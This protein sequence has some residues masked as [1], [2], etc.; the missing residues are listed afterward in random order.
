MKS[1]STIKIGDCDITKQ[2]FIDVN[3]EIAKTRIFIDDN[4][5]KKIEDYRIRLEKEFKKFL[6][7]HRD[8]KCDPDHKKGNLSKIHSLK[9]LDD[10]NKLKTQMSTWGTGSSKV[11]VFG[12]DF[13]DDKIAKKA[14]ELADKCL[15][16]R[17]KS[18]IIGVEKEKA[19]AL[20]AVAGVAGAPATAKE[21]E[22]DAFGFIKIVRSK[23]SNEPVRVFVGETAG[24]TTANIWDEKTKSYIQVELATTKIGEGANEKTVI[25]GIKKVEQYTQNGHKIDPPTSLLKIDFFIEKTGDRSGL[26]ALDAPPAPAQAPG[27]NLQMLHKTEIRNVAQSDQ[28]YYLT[29][30]FAHH[31]EDKP[32]VVSAGGSSKIIGKI[33]AKDLNNNIQTRDIND[34]TSQNGDILFNIETK[35]QDNFKKTDEP[36]ISEFMGKAIPKYI[37]QKE[38]KGIVLRSGGKIAEANITMEKEIS[39]ELLKVLCVFAK[40]SDNTSASTRIGLTQISRTASPPA[41][42]PNNPSGNPAQVTKPRCFWTGP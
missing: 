40:D 9:G 28:G 38:V 32:Y 3:D 12:D 30:G 14:K 17:F 31:E 6:E 4:G 11:K 23:K 24:P 27:S 16:N 8:K 15:A 26:F 34:L 2:S 36:L 39:S 33:K 21:Y 42:S 41:S 25:E 7:D 20:V 22:E 19:P 18:G 35:R 29:N 13:S 5:R 10:L 37:P 1:K